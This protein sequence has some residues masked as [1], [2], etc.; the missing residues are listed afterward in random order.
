LSIRE[1]F[2]LWRMLTSWVNCLP[3]DI[4]QDMKEREPGLFKPSLPDERGR[5]W[6]PWGEGYQQ[7]VA[8]LTLS[9]QGRQP[10]TSEP[11]HGQDHIGQ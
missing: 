3:D 6:F 5:T 7:L 8:D 9:A 10:K 11:A 4:L 1:Q 2:K